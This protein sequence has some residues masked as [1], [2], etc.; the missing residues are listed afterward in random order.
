MSTSVRSTPLRAPS[1]ST[2]G[3]HLT[4]LL[5][6]NHW[7]R[8]FRAYST[9][10]RA[11]SAFAVKQP[12]PDL[13]TDHDRDLAIGLLRREATVSGQVR[14]RNLAA[15][16]DVIRRGDEIWL[17]QPFLAGAALSGPRELA[18]SVTLWAIRQTA[19]ALAALH[20]AGWLHGNV[21]AEAI[22]MGTAGYTTLG[23]LGWC[24]QLATE[25]CDLGRTAFLGQI[26]YAAP[27]M[28]D[29]AG[30]M[31][32]AADLYSLG[33][34]L[35]ELLTGCVPFADYDGPEMIAAKRLLAAPELESVVLPYEVSSLTARMLSRDP[36]RR[37][38]ADEVVDT[39]IAAEIAT[40]PG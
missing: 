38:T 4:E 23:E 19:Q 5:S 2:A 11:G 29:D 35:A 3:W 15:T 40:L 37:P 34:V 20:S 26:A 27:E 25:E 9:V 8:T 24:R 39:L 30:M 10:N 1:R 21:S 14:Q 22:V 28:F 7:T 32:P 36:L 18:L 6:Q 31:T 12:R 13:A 17:V 16:L 33:V